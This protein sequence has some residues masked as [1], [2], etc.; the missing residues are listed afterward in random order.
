MGNR[1]WKVSSHKRSIKVADESAIASNSKSSQNND[2]DIKASHNDSSKLN[3]IGSLN[4]EANS[5][6]DDMTNESILAPTY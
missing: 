4:N 6:N 1:K 3:L 2:S 5:N